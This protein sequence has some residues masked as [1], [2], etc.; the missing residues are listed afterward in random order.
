MLT[1]IVERVRYLQV[2]IKEGVRDDSGILEIGDSGNLAGD[3]HPI[4]DCCGP[5]RVDELSAPLLQLFAR[6]RHDVLLW[7]RAGFP[8]LRDKGRGMYEQA[9]RAGHPQHLFKSTHMIIVPVTDHNGLGLG[10]IDPESLGVFHDNAS[11]A[12]IEQDVVLVGLDEERHP[13]FA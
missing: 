8:V 7:A 4:A 1:V 3:H 5:F 10:E 13:P 6:N 11:T 12:G 9:D 2:R